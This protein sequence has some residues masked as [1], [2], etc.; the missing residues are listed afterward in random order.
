MNILYI[1][2]YAGSPDMGME[3]RPY[4]LS[5]E[6]V[7]QGHHVSIIAGDYSH[8]RKK[9]PRIS[10]D[11]K[12]STIDGID[13]YWLRTG[14][15]EGNGTERALTMLRFCGKLKKYRQRICEL[16]NPDVII[17]S[18]TYPIDAI[19]AHKIITYAEKQTSCACNHGCCHTEGKNHHK[20][21]VHIHEV[22]DMWPSTLIELGGMSK[23]NPFVMLMQ[24]GENFA[25]SHA[26]AVVSLPGNAEEYMKKHGLREGCFFHIPNGV[27]TEEWYYPEKLPEEHG[28]ILDQLKKEGKFIVG[29]FGGHA[30]SNCLGTLVEAARM[31]DDENRI[32]SDESNTNRKNKSRSGKQAHFVL[33]GDGVEKPDLIN[34]AKGLDNI[35]FLPPVPKLA[36][37]ALT[38]QFDAIYIGAMDSPL[39]R[40]GVCMNKMFDGMMAGKPIL[41][42]INSPTT[43]V[44]ECD[45]GR[46]L[47]PEDADAIV[48]SVRELMD[49]PV[50]ERQKM[51][52]RGRHEILE[53]YTYRKLAEEFLNVIDQKKESSV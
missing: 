44:E 6:W 12:K 5:R 43:P 36:I 48:S 21:I 26:D 24:H 23:L 13:Y 9:N 8:L 16:T 50:S 19:A 30:L 18:S 1:E 47:P 35:T 53:K 38:D 37:P 46:I 39:Y 33:V 52:E 11:L 20:K 49:L 2:H 22:H 34:A 41:F 51:G 15:Y 40:F 25:Y 27:V 3:F 45:C 31:M 14:E 42:A 17:S 10:H 28:R 4:Y 7:R 29:Y 32:K